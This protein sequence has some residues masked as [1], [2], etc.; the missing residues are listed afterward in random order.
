[1]N[2]PDSPDSPAPSVAAKHG[3]IPQK[4]SVEPAAAPQGRRPSRGRRRSP[5]Q[6]PRH[7]ITA[8]SQRAASFPSVLLCFGSPRHH[9]QMGRAELTPSSQQCRRH[10]P[11]K[12]M[13]GPFSAPPFNAY[14]VSP[15]GVATRK[16]S[17]KKHLILDLSSPHNSPFPSINSLIPLE[18][19]SLRYHDIDQAIILIKDADR[20]AWLAKLNITSSFRVMPIHPDFWHLLGIRWRNKFYFAVC[21]T[22]GCR[23]SPK[24]FDMLSR[25]FHTARDSPRPRQNHRSLYLHRI[26]GHQSRF[27]EIPSL[28]TQ[29]KIDRTILFVSTLIDNPSCSKHELLSVLG[30]LNFAIHIIPQGCP[31]VSHLLSLAYSAQTLE[32]ITD[33]CRSELSLWI[34]FLSQWNGLSFFYN[35]L[36]S[37]I[38]RRRPF[39]RLWRILPRPLVRIH[40]ARPATRSNAAAN[41]HSPFRAIPPGGR[42]SPVGPFPFT[43]THALAETP[44][45]DLGSRPVHHNRKARSRKFKL[46]APEAEQLPTPV[47]HYSQLIFPYTIHCQLYVKLPSVPFYKLSR[48]EPS[49]PI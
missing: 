29:R 45:L 38:Y 33:S 32:D 34:S 14:R 41:I 44:D 26:P 47:P 15:L 36:I 11:V 21:L 43:R 4:T 6:T 18:E 39:C 49:N 3:R 10:C 48:P 9:G 23:S 24:I 16:F 46:L 27:P 31:F 22:F 8:A 19:F 25:R 37:L 30:H 20:G 13:I 17:G 1:M 28:P 35:N 40:L 42:S 7:A 2:S 12:F 5:Y